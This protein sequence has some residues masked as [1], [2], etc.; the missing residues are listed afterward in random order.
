MANFRNP[1]G[2][3]IFKWVPSVHSKAEENQ[4]GL[5]VGKRPHFVV[6]FL[7]QEIFYRILK[8]RTV[9]SRFKLKHSNNI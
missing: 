8:P 6:I 4:I 5:A 2:V 9:L 3:Y 7:E 1:F